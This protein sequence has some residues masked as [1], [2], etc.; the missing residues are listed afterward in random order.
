MPQ[1]ASAGRPFRYCR[2][3]DD[4][5]LR[6]ARN[7]RMR[8]RGTPGLAGQV[9]QAFE[10]VERLDKVVETLTEALHTELSPAG[11]DRQL[12][13]LRAQTAADVAAAHAER[14]EARREAEQW[15][16]EAARLRAESQRVRADSTRTVAAALAEAETARRLAEEAVALADERVADAE[17]ATRA[18]RQST[19]EADGR[20]QAMTSERDAALRTSPRPRPCTPRRSASG[21]PRGPRWP[22]RT[23]RPRPPRPRSGCT[24][25]RPRRRWPGPRRPP[26]ARWPSSGR[27]WSGRSPRPRNGSRSSSPPATALTT[28]ERRNA[29]LAAIAESLAQQERDAAQQPRPRRPRSTR[30]R[31]APARDARGSRAREAEAA[32]RDAAAAQAHAAQLAEQVGQLAAALSRL[33]APA[34]R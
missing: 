1:R 2:D 21:T 26:A 32:R 7:A 25:P 8:A 16:D 17:A 29:E 34:R 31:D 11:V 20:T 9:A 33:S 30:R 13:S 10:V 27:R 22:T 5:C 3:N 15:Q 23:G 28:V 4:A 6:A 18:A 12:N 14:D 19:V 24:R